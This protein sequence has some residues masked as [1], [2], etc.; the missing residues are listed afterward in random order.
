MGQRFW[1]LMKRRAERSP[2]TMGLPHFGV[3]FL[4]SAPTVEM[5]GVRGSVWGNLSPGNDCMLPAGIVI[6]SG[7]TRRY[8][9]KIL[10]SNETQSREISCHHGLATFQSEISPL[11]DD[12]R[13]DGRWSDI[14]VIHAF[15]HS[16]FFHVQPMTAYLLLG[17]DFRAG[18][19]HHGFP[20]EFSVISFSPWASLLVRS[21]SIPSRLDVSLRLTMAYCR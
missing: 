16:L 2:A 10:G 9:A 11:R 17:G 12:R 5:T 18:M 6:S 15:L 7:G 3:R 8:G 4:H 20:A 19:F 21:C 1:A 13:N 14:D